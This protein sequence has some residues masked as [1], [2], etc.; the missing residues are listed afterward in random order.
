M[1][2]SAMRPLIQY[3]KRTIVTVVFG[4]CFHASELIAIIPLASANRLG[5]RQDELDNPS[6]PGVVASSQFLQFPPKIYDC[7][8][9]ADRSPKVLDPI[10][11]GRS[12]HSR[13]LSR[14]SRSKISMFAEIRLNSGRYGKHSP[15][16][17]PISPPWFR[18]PCH[19]ND[20]CEA[21]EKG[22]SHCLP[23]FVP[24][25]ASQSP[26]ALRAR[27]SVE[28]RQGRSGIQ[29]VACTVAEEVERHE[30]KGVCI[31]A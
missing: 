22:E 31:P 10:A 14:P 13:H 9:Q 8:A 27:H 1:E 7:R 4:Q 17:D 23:G 6:A 24:L 28:R 21:L 3:D 16:L 11:F 12:E 18:Q 19:S 2:C 26:E 5:N 30:L 29:P 20:G 25:G 15:W